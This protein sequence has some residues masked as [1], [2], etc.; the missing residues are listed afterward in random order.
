MKFLK[1]GACL[2]GTLYLGVF[3]LALSFQSEAQLEKKQI[4]LAS[5]LHEFVDLSTLPQ[6]ETATVSAQ[7]SSYD[8]TGMNNDGF[9]G[10]YSFLRRNPDSTLV[11]F[12]QTGPGV[13]N[14]IWTPTPSSDTLDF[15]IDDPSLPAFSI[16]Y[17]D[18]FSGNVF[19]FIGPL[20][21]NQ[22]GGYYCY[23]PIPFNKFC[24]IVLKAKHTMFHQVGYRLYTKG[25][26]VKSFSRLLDDDAKK[27]LDLIQRIWLKPFIGA[28]DIFGSESLMKETKKSITLKPG[29]HKMVFQS[30]VPGRILGFELL[31]ASTLDSIARRI[32]LRITWD[33]DK[34]PAVYAPLSDYFGYAF[35]KPGMNGLLVGSDGKRH[36]SWFPMP[37]DRS[38]KVELI[39]RTDGDV[40]ANAEVKLQSIF[41]LADKKRDIKSEGK[42]YGQWNRENPVANGK[43]YT[44]LSVQGKGHFAGVVLQ[45]Q[46]LKPGITIFFEGDDS[47]VIDGKMRLHGTGSED[48]FNGGWYA[49]LD[50]WDGAMSLPLSGSLEYSIPWSRTGG[51]RYFITDKLT[52]EKSFLQTIEHGPDHNRW[53]ADYR[54]VSYYY[55]DRN[56][57]QKIYPANDNTGYYRPDTMEI[58]PQ[59]TPF[60]MD[61]TI[62]IDSKWDGSPA[63]TMFYTVTERSHLRL[64]L[65]EIPPGDYDIYFDYRKGSDAATFSVWQRQ[66]QVS[67]WMDAFAQQAEKHPMQKISAVRLTPLNNSISLRFRTPESRNKFTLTRII[68][69]RKKD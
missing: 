20:C 17:M 13:V 41:Y 3:L 46:G 42:F 52:F 40:V 49:L 59:L 51:Y 55:C 57:R 37:F 4:S 44:M 60:I 18:L 61:E 69:V 47:T 27:Q 50:R 12:E 56:N 33:N 58:Y 31:S 54:S 67:P 8:T 64:S 22:L 26:S 65:A 45:A 15:Y 39:Y 10:N 32:D 24:R 23:L 62:A 66:T 19:P 11:I 21:A 30:A 53:P 28:R 35:G 29:E 7:T 9:G 68:L 16:S 34:F 14:R 2:D 63:K 5:L 25:T 38:A 1:S 36:Y 43:P 48:F 6:Y